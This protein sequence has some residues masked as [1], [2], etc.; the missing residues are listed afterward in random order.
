LNESI[1]AASHL[2]RLLFPGRL[3]SVLSLADNYPH[4][5]EYTLS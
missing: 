4:E 5:H 2:L 3:N 1:V